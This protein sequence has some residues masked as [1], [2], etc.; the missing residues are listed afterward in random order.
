ML[1]RILSGLGP[2]LWR[3]LPAEGP[4]KITAGRQLG[5][6]Q[7]RI[8]LQEVSNVIVKYS[9]YSPSASSVDVRYITPRRSGT[10]RFCNDANTGPSASSTFGTLL[11]LYITQPGS[12]K[13]LVEECCRAAPRRLRDRRGRSACENPT[14]LLIYLFYCAFKHKIN[15]C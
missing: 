12:G 15:Y 1:L 13:N 7:I 14:K 5:L 9:R 8:A 2:F 6:L 11:L 10:S 4:Q 3:I